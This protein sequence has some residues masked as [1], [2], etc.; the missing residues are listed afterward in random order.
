MTGL[1]RY[2]ACRVPLSAWDAIL[3]P[4][5]T[6]ERVLTRISTVESLL[7]G[8]L[9]CLPAAAGVC[10]E[11]AG[12]CKALTHT[13][14]SCSSA[15]DGSAHLLQLHSIDSHAVH[16]AYRLLCMSKCTCACSSSC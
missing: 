9:W 5:G 6:L 14:Q 15:A 4:T 13:S 12:Q 1:C 7:K 3:G 10:N 2:G 11:S 8:T 16:D